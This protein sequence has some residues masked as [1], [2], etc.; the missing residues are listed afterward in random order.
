[1]HVV[2]KVR[3]VWKLLA[4]ECRGKD[5]HP[6]TNPSVNEDGWQEMCHAVPM[7]KKQPEHWD[8][9][10]V[11]SCFQKLKQ[12]TMLGVVEERLLHVCR[13]RYGPPSECLLQLKGRYRY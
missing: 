10:S 6:S 5:G 8:L 3:V 1:M 2:N 4:P 12:L 7:V 13:R 9:D 11:R